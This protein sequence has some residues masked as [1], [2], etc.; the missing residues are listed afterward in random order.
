MIARIRKGSSTYA[1]YDLA[2]DN[3]EIDRVSV[4]M[5]DNNQNGNIGLAPIRFES[6]NGVNNK[7]LFDITGRISLREYACKNI[8]QNEF[9]EMVTCLVE[10]I[11]GFEE[12]MIDLA[13]VMLDI[14]N[15]YIN[16]LDRSVSFICIALKDVTQQGNLERFFRE[17]LE[18]SRVVNVNN[19]EKNYFHAVWNVV[20]SG[21]GFSLDNIMT[22]IKGVGG[23][24]APAMNAPAMN[25][26]AAPNQPAQPASAPMAAAAPASVGM[27]MPA[28]APS[29]GQ[30][31]LSGGNM[32]V[33]G[34][35]AAPVNNFEQT[36]TVN[37]ATSVSMAPQPVQEEEKSGGLF[38][39]KK[40]KKDKK[41]VKKSSGGLADRLKNKGAA[42]SGEQPQQPEQQ[43]PQ[44]AAQQPVAQPAQPAFIGGTT[45]LGGGV[46]TPTPVQPPQQNNT[47]P[48]SFGMGGNNNPMSQ[49]QSF[50]MGGNNNPMPQSQSFGMGGNNNPMPQSQSFGMGGN[51]NPMPQSQSFG[52]GGNNNPMPQSQSFGMGGNSNP[53][54]QP[55]SAP[56]PVQT[57]GSPGTTVLQQP[58]AASKDTT[59]LVSNE[60]T[61]YLIRTANGDRVELTKSEVKLGRDRADMDYCV[62]NNT[63]VGHFHA[64]I[65]VEADGYFI[66]DNNSKNHTYVND[67]MIVS[68]AKTRLLNGAVI[69]LADEEFKFVLVL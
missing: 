20:Q 3:S 14:D 21:S 58:A 41:E 12:Y 39:R 54:P 31:G 23:V 5:I 36:V 7:M 68:G 45:V 34:F 57:A 13:Q 44:P 46:N 35:G 67:Q 42:A 49:P 32:G 10:S 24:G 9:R 51:N 55:Q 59:V 52:M 60:R 26:P 47:Q 69:K 25:R 53:V 61:A 1:V 18:N 2:D 30:N 33:G 64:R 17:L 28:S 15:V 6:I 37:P 50:G 4:A 56:A 65:L 16:E 43:I 8:T 63:N 48:Q 38:G 66:I 29:N 27:G 40:H 22:A 62:N 11:E 19:N